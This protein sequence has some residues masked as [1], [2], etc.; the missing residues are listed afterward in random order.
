MAL[1]QLPL[2]DSEIRS[3]IGQ[4][5]LCIFTQTV[6][7]YIFM[8]LCFLCYDSSY[9]YCVLFYFG[10]YYLYSFNE[11]KYLNYFRKHLIV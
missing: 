3:W 5:E 4:V 1:S 9:L 11:L 8:S 2:P 6:L 7:K 10:G